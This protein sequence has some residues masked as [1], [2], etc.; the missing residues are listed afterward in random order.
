MEIGEMFI[1]SAA[2]DT[3]QGKAIAGV[4]RKW[5]AA[6]DEGQADHKNGAHIGIPVCKKKY[7]PF[8]IQ[9]DESKGSGYRVE[10]MFGCHCHS[11]L[12]KKVIETQGE[13]NGWEPF[14]QWSLE[15]ARMSAIA[16]LDKGDER[17]KVSCNNGLC[18]WKKRG[19]LDDIANELAAK[20]S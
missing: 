12:R 18:V 9:K 1:K 20:S 2:S 3:L 16:S 6:F 11:N 10:R 4:H 17:P 7:T 15:K 19:K 13:R 5:A 8:T 14:G